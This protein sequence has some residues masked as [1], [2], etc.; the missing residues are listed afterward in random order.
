[1]VI[2]KRVKINCLPG[3]LWNWLV[4]FDKL[5]KWNSSLLEEQLISTGESRVGFKSR[6]LIA[7]GKK[8]VWYDHVLLN[9]EPPTFLS[10]S[11]SGG[12]LGKSPMTVDY[13]IHRE[14]D[15][16]L[17]TYKSSWRARGLILNILQ[18]FIKI[19]AN[20]N[21]EKCMASLRKCIEQ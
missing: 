4:E 2:N 19:A 3:E 12:S 10:I 7:E 14:G 15:T 13:Q 21:A 18:P 16:S 17:L 8:K 1:M 6:I 5:K 11:L 9:Y 20:K